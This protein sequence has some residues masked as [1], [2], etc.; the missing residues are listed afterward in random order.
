MLYA[1]N[2][3]LNEANKKR[4]DGQTDTGKYKGYFALSC[5]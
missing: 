4:M 1:K 3:K 2:A 5:L